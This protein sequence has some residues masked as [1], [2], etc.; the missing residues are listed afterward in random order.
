MAGKVIRR[1]GKDY[2][3]VDKYP[4]MYKSLDGY[5]MYRLVHKASKTDTDVWKNNLTNEIFTKLEEAVKDR[6]RRLHELGDQKITKYDAFTVGQIWEEMSTTTTDKS[7]STIRKHSS[8]YTHHIKPVFENTKLK[9]LTV[10]DINE[11]LVKL[12]KEGDGSTKHEGGYKYSFVESI[13][14][15]FYWFYNFCYEKEYIKK[16][17]LDK[18]LEKVHMP[19]QKRNVKKDKLRVL[20][21]E[22]ITQILQLLRGSKLFIPT[23]ISLTTGLRP[24]ECF[25]LT[26]EDID[27][28]N[29]IL[30]VNQKISEEPGGKLV[31]TAPKTSA[32]IRPVNIPKVLL[33]ELYE[34]KRKIYEARLKDP[35]LFESNRGKIFIEENLK[36]S[37]IDMPNFVCIDLCGRYIKPSAFNY[38]AKIIRAEICPNIKGIEDFSFNTFRKTH[39]SKMAAYLPELVLIKHTGHAKIDTIRQYYSGESDDTLA[40]IKRTVDDIGS[41]FGDMLSRADENLN[42]NP[43]K[44]YKDSKSDML[45]EDE[46]SDATVAFVLSSDTASVTDSDDIDF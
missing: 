37:P 42:N 4:Y 32:S 17:V 41:G 35:A 23:L 45:I 34:H 8:V 7:D 13:L 22:E 36:K 3:K 27:F 30:H 46:I 11:L 33:N 15:W 31:I 19:T 38:W 43:Q 2:Y 25:A 44:H 14:K 24:S 10:A 6:L 28:E 40:A 5:Y 21:N 16:D 26:W 18:F 1:N 9:D 12:Y 29:S 39:I 20:T